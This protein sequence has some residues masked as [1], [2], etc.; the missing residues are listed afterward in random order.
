MNAATA[1]ERRAE[2]RAVNAM[3]NEITIL[4]DRINA[5]IL[6]DRNIRTAFTSTLVIH[7]PRIFEKGLSADGSKIGIYSTKPSSISK[8]RQARNTGKTYFKGGYSEYKTDIGKNPGFVILRDRDQMY[9]DY[10]VYG[11]AGV[12]GIGFQNQFNADKSGWMEDYFDKKIFQLNENEVQ[13]FKSV[14]IAAIKK[15]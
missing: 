10:G 2:R 15:A 12:W 6:D 7:K 8:S 3:A 4:V 14:M 5:A 9:A 13:V 1:A 11:S